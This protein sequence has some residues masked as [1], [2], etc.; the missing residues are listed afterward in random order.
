[1]ISLTSSIGKSTTMLVILGLLAT[2]TKFLRLQVDLFVDPLHVR[3]QKIP[4]FQKSNDL[5]SF[6]RQQLVN[7]LVGSCSVRAEN[8]R[9]NGNFYFFFVVAIVEIVRVQRDV[10]ASSQIALLQSFMPF[11]SA[12]SLLLNHCL[13]IFFKLCLHSGDVSINAFNK[14]KQ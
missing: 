3:I 1:M 14:R 8:F 9:K 4:V 5:F 11:E 12:T 10:R 13:V 2:P 6:Q 7:Y